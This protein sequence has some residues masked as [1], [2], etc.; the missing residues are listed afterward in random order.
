MATQTQ[1]DENAPFEVRAEESWYDRWLAEREVNARHAQQHSVLLS[2][3]AKLRQQVKELQTCEVDL[4]GD[5]AAKELE[6]N[7]AR[8]VITVL[9][10]ESVWMKRHFVN[11]TDATFRAI[12]GRSNIPHEAAELV[13][14]YAGVADRVDIQ[15]ATADSAMQTATKMTDLLNGNDPPT[16]GKR[17]LAGEIADFQARVNLELANY[18]KDSQI[19]QHEFAKLQ[20]QAVEN[21]RLRNALEAKHKENLDVHRLALDLAHESAADQYFDV[22]ARQARQIVH[23]REVREAMREWGGAGADAAGGGAVA[24]PRAALDAALAALDVLAGGAANAAD[25]A[26][27]DRLHLYN[28]SPLARR[29]APVE[30][31]THANA[32]VPTWEK[33]VLLGADCLERADRM[34]AARRA[35]ALAQGRERRDRL[36]ASTRRLAVRAYGPCVVSAR[37]HDRLRVVR[38]EA[39][40]SLRAKCDASVVFTEI[41]TRCEKQ[42]L[43]DDTTL[44][45]LNSPPP[46]KNINEAFFRSIRPGMQIVGAECEVAKVTRP[47][48]ETGAAS[49][50]AAP[51]PAPRASLQSP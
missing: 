22:F 47:S 8:A 44:A 17:R 32:L 21:V 31:P 20:G 36:V 23:A 6:K 27:E 50:R 35:E 1:T 7:E 9:K 10:N 37:A 48:S 3:V 15:C 49:T 18:L 41:F 11:S 29:A 26:E 28:V 42:G 33:N 13:T 39:I 46:L 2:M 14:A 43:L 40:A 5:L 4:R 45:L 38:E 30:A 16:P 34:D 19:Q 25:N 12:C 51:T 24:V